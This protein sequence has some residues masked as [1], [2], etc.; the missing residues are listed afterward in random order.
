MK[1]TSIS[2]SSHQKTTRRQF[3]RSGPLNLPKIITKNHLNIFIT[4]NPSIIITQAKAHEDSQ[5]PFQEDDHPN[6]LTLSTHQ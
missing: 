1:Q 3:S 5:P 2:K 4:Q 6:N